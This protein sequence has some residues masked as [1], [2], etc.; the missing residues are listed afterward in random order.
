MTTIASLTKQLEFLY[1]FDFSYCSCP[2]ERELSML[3]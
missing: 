2:L 1:I 3:N